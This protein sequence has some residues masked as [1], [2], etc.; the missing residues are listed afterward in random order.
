MS[1]AS[2]ILFN[3]LP[4]K[5]ESTGLSRYSE[6]L[7]ASWT[8]ATGYSL[9]LQLRLSKIGNAELLR[10]QHLPHCQLSVRMRWLQRNGLV[11][12][13]ISVRKFIEK[14]KPDIIYS[15]YTDLLMAVKNI[16]QVITCHDLTPLYFPS[17]CRAYWRS[18]LWL[19][20]HLHGAHQI[21][22]IS[23]SVADQLIKNNFPSQ[24][25][26]IIPNGVESV[27]RPIAHPESF[28]FLVI[29]RHASNKNLTLALQGFANFLALEPSW[30]GSLV[31]VG[32]RGAATKSLSCLEQE[33]SLQGR[34]RW[35][36]YLEQNALERQLRKSFCLLSTSL[37]E[38]FDYPLLEAQVR[39]LP[40][41]AS[42]IAVHEELYSETS[43]LFDLHDKGVSLGFQL[44]QLALD[45]SLW[46]QLSQLGLTQV[47]QF[48]LE[49]QTRSI[50]DLLE[51]NTIRPWH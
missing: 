44:R 2:P 40:T 20:R 29:A 16:P 34:I 9:P 43:L 19:P 21:I 37:M 33:L 38:G 8:E 17:S 4:Y 13:G 46:Q 45:N 41:L 49:S 14:A 15:P 36:T 22:A 1:A 35:I 27:K 32:G 24:K 6:R 7:L 30:P 31:I 47:Q 11:Q 23:R 39:G 48:S 51:K 10:N 50:A 5:P 28:D 18:K 12:H 25:I 3:L 42:R 26:T